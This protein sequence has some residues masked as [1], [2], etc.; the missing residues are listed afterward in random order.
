M[1]PG[2]PKQLKC[3]KVGKDY[4][5]ID[6]KPPTEDGGS[7]VTGYRIEKCEET[8]DEWVKVEEV[9][10]YDTNFK[11][12]KLKDTVGYFFSVSAKNEVGY[13]EPAETD[14][15][16]KPKRPEGKI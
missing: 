1:P 12:E 16:I 8:A 3:T 11:I 5:I 7:K 15:A 10:A 9:K 6:W 13:S 4:I 14:D 2:P